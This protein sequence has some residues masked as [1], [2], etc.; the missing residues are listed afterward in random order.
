MLALFELRED[1]DKDNVMK[2]G[3]VTVYFLKESDG[4][5]IRQAT[6]LLADAYE[7]RIKP[8]V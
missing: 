7:K 3:T 5:G 2:I 8:T 1:V 4:R 6:Q